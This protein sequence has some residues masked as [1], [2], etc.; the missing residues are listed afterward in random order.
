MAFCTAGAQF[1]DSE[2]LFWWSNSPGFHSQA[3]LPVPTL[4]RASM[5]PLTYEQAWSHW[6][7]SEHGAT[8][9]WQTLGS[10]EGLG[11]YCQWTVSDNNCTG[12]GKRQ[13]SYSNWYQSVGVFRPMAG[14]T[15][16]CCQ[17]H[18]YDLPSLSNLGFLRILKGV[19]S[20]SRMLGCSRNVSHDFWTK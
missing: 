17:S 6:P 12:P 20:R 11:F 2:F 9:L 16:G 5:E 7:M 1:W 4:L 19:F 10:E 8:D 3:Q 13:D 15:F 18:G 14:A